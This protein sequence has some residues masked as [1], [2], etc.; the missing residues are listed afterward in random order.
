[1]STANPELAYLWLTGDAFRGLAGMKMPEDPFAKTLDGMKH[2]GGIEAGFAQSATQKID[3][4]KVWNFEAP[5]KVARDPLEEGMKFRAVDNTE[6]TALTRAQGGTISKNAAGFY[7]LEKGIGEEFSFLA[8]FEDGD[9]QGAIWCE[10][11]TLGNPASRAQIDGQNIDGWEFD[12]VFL[13]KPKEIL[14][15]LPDGMTDPTAP[16]TGV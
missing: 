3:K 13:T 6:A 9:D 2:Y 15:A 5:Y 4:K 7:I 11:V 10:R 1:M 12:L 16:P 14:P 8:R